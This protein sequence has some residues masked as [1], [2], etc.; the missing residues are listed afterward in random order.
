[1]AST[2]GCRRRTLHA[3]SDDWLA[4][5]VLSLGGDAVVTN[6]PEVTDLV[7]RRAAQALVAYGRP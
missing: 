6:R 5:L 7:A 1:L 4:R 3:G 2:P